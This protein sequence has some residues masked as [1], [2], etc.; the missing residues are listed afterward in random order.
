MIICLVAISVCSILPLVKGYWLP[1]SWARA[2]TSTKQANSVIIKLADFTPVVKSA[3]ERLFLV[4]SD[5]FH[6][7]VGSDYLSEQ[8]FAVAP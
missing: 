5:A 2:E 3:P 6:Q 1:G 8:K 4:H 7:E